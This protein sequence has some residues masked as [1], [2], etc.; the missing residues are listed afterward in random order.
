VLERDAGC[1]GNISPV[2]WPG[3]PLPAEPNGIVPGSRL[4]AAISSASVL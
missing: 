1:L 3:V 2:R 4:A